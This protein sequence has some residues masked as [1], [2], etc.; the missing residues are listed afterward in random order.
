MEFK[1]EIL[2]QYQ[3]LMTLGYELSRVLRPSQY[4]SQQ[5]NWTAQ[6]K[7]NEFVNDIL[8][9]DMKS[10]IQDVDDDD[11][12]QEEKEIVDNHF[13]LKRDRKINTILN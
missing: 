8:V 12:Y 13:M 2:K 6:Y 7:L 11:Y 5:T 9:E 4:G 10:D 1:E 3:F